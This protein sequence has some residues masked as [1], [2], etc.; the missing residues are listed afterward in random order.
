MCGW[1]TKCDGSPASISYCDRLPSKRKNHL[2]VGSGNIL[3]LGA[4]G[5]ERLRLPC[6][7]K[8]HAGVALRGLSME[9]HRAGAWGAEPPG[10]LLGAVLI[11]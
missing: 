10:G 3:V 1:H 7:S 4:A 2:P 8:L 9:S 11:G 6:T 5:G